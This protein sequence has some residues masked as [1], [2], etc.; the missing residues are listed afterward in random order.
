MTR[1]ILPAAFL[2]IALLASPLPLSAGPVQIDIREVTSPG[3][4]TAWLVED[5]TLPFV[6]I[7]LNFSGGPLAE[8]ADQRGATYLMTALLEE[9]AGDLDA[10][11]FAIARDG[12]GA[13][14]GF[15]TFSDG[16]TVSARFLTESRAEGIDLLRTALAAPRFDDE[17]VERVR[18]QLLASISARARNP[19]DIAREA[20]AAATFG[21]HP[22]GQP[23]RGSA[24]SVTSL[25]VDDLR[26]AHARALTRA[27]VSIG[28][29]GD[30]TPEELGPLLDHLLGGL[31]EA[32]PDLPARPVPDLSGGVEVIAFPGPQSV[33][34]FGHGGVARDDPD[35]F[36]AFVLD[37][38]LGGSGL[39]SRLFEELREKRGLTYGV[40]T[41]LVLNDQAEL[42]LG[43]FAADNARVAEAMELVRSEWRRAA[44]E[45]I[46]DDELAAAKS[47]LTGAYPLRFEG[48]ARIAGI[49]AWLQAADLPQDYIRTRNAAVEAVSAEDVR[50]AAA[51][52]LRTDDLRFVV[53][54]SPGELPLTQ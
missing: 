23:I 48:N 50:R 2:G 11:A 49:L 40:G 1:P 8:P 9:G 17:A 34:A 15:S 3:G 24:E 5:S 14:I 54:G 21:D 7:E 12:L 39:T 10:E 38:V 43:Q 29:A 46:T 4:L 18:G 13:R 51:R 44:E 27:G 42:W 22:Y 31:P 36:P 20:F 25:T 28:V 35:F 53:V 6:A 30:I 16:V 41:G 47:Y 32:G 52:L 26:A 45:G 19:R 33:V 37:H